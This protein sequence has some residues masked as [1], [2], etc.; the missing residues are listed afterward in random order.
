MHQNFYIKTNKYFKVVGWGAWGC[1][2][3]SGNLP[4]VHSF[5]LK[6]SILRQREDSLFREHTQISGCPNDICAQVVVVV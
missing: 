4:R 3:H 2:V 5:S 6:E 1:T